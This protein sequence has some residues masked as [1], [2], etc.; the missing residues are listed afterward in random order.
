MMNR[1]LLIVLTC[2]VFSKPLAAQS[3]EE[4]AVANAVESLR[5]ALIDPDNATLAKLTFKELTY[6]HSTGRVENQKEFIESLVSGKSDFI[7]IEVT[8]QTIKL[9]GNTA[10]VHHSLFGQ[11]VD[12]GNPGTAKL[13]VM[14]T[15]QKQNGKWKLLVRQAVKQPQ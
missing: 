3:K 2:L 14:Y 12:N 8:N 9:V 1:A 10:I 7:S 5:K 15:W 4:K 6:G 13:Y 11:T